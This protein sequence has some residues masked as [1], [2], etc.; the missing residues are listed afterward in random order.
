MPFNTTDQGVPYYGKP[1]EPDVPVAPKEP[2]GERIGSSLLSAMVQ[3]ALGRER[4]QIEREQMVQAADISAKDMDLKRQQLGMQHEYQMGVLKARALNSDL[5]LKSHA[6]IIGRMAQVASDRYERDQRQNA[7]D[8]KA[9][10]DAG[11][12][13]DPTYWADKPIDAAD[14]FLDWSG[15]YGSA[16]EGR[17]PRQ[18]KEWQA[19]AD[20]TKITQRVGAQWD[21]A[22]D[23]WTGGKT[24]SRP[25]V[26]VL[27]EWKHNPNERPRMTQE[28]LAA[29]NT[30]SV[31]HLNNVTKQQTKTTKNM[32][33]FGATVGTEDVSEP[34]VQKT[35]STGMDATT[36]GYLDKTNN[37][38][39]TPGENQVP[40]DLQ[41]K[42]HKGMPA[43]PAYDPP[44]IP[45][46]PLPDTSY[47]TPTKTDITLQ[48]ARNA[49]A[50]N[51]QAR[52]TIEQRLSSMGID[53]VHLDA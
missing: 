37:L 12:L 35:R 19:K 36:Q 31:E 17:V 51:P 6:T 32:F 52:G 44:D 20:L 9:M 29:G 47:N 40:P 43:P 16:V 39:L 1:V 3:G 26:Q 24:V 22:K 41:T 50:A 13:N 49:L 4:A 5:A 15:R 34:F 2:Q 25:A 33:G 21:N 42:Y 10:Q 48:H 7:F 14:K 28:L 8:D 18:M 30:T 45:D 11:K 53:P 23:Q 27:E 38:K 46:A